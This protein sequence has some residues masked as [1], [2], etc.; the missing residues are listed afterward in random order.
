VKEIHDPNLVFY[1]SLHKTDG[2]SLISQDAHGHQGAVTGAVWTPQG[3]SFDGVDDIITVPHSPSLNV[4]SGITMALWVKPEGDQENWAILMEKPANIYSIRFDDSGL[5]LN[6]IISIS[7]TLRYPPT[8]ISLAQ[9]EFSFVMVTWDGAEGRIR[10]Y[11]NGV[12]RF[13]S[14]PYPGTIDTSSGDLT[15]GARTTTVRRIK[16][17]I[18]MAYLNERALSGVEGASLYQNTKRR[19]Q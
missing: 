7:G 2:N 19:Y 15:I 10:T 13:A 9:G 5:G 16:G 3:R 4:T 6:P 18:G 8:G 12:L 11:I 1:L 17:T 14:D